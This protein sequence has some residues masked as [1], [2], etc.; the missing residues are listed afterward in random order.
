[1]DKLIKGLL[2]NQAVNFIAIDGTRLV[3]RAKQLHDASATCTAALGRTL[4]GTSMLGAMEKDKNEV[5]VIIKGGGQA[6]NIVC[7][8]RN[9]GTVKGYIGD[10]HVELPAKANGKLDVAGVVGHFGSFTVVRDMGLKE[11]YIGST[12]LVSGE[13]AEDFAAYFA[14]SQQQPSLIYLGVHINKEMGVSAAAGIF[15]QPLPHCP[16]S[17]IAHLESRTDDIAGLGALLEDGLSFEAALEKIFFNM[18]LEITQTLEPTFRCDCSNE[19]LENVVISLGAEEINDMIIKDDGA[20]L[21]CH[22][23]N[24][25]YSYTAEQLRALL[26]AATT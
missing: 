25:K 1:M 20:Q 4:M 17:V 12:E 7:V 2:C 14:I 23:C 5:T 6:G 16:E 21:T 8:G 15:V 13:I 10:P 18:Q 3:E 19:R 9:D 22:F 26:R 11:P 24:K